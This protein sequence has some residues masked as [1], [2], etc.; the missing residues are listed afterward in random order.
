MPNQTS[1]EA[2]NPMIFF[3]QLPLCRK[4]GIIH[5]MYPAA[6]AIAICGRCS[7]NL[8]DRVNEQKKQGGPFGSPQEEVMKTG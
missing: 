7:G 5:N 8:R 6:L 2:I 3:F 1:I 4:T